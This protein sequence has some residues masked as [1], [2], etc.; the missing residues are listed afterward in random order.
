MNP[1]STSDDIERQLAAM[2]SVLRR[3]VRGFAKHA[4]TLVDWRYYFRAHPWLYCGGAAALGFMLV[5]GR[6]QP[7]TGDDKGVVLRPGDSAH[8]GGSLLK[9]IFTLAATTVVRESFGYLIQ[10]SRRDP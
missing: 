2:R 9:T 4:R 3:D 10:R 7:L 5:S 1:V 6:E 8:S